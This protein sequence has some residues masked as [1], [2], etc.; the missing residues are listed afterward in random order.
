[1]NPNQ[2]FSS[3]NNGSSSIS[4]SSSVSRYASFSSSSISGSSSVSRYASFSSSSI[5]GSSS[6]SRY[7]SIVLV[8]AA[9]LNINISSSS[10]SVFAIRSQHLWWQRLMPPFYFSLFLRFVVAE[11]GVV[12]AVAAVVVVIVG[13]AVGV[14]AAVE[15]LVAVDREM[16]Q[17]W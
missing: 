2:R 11:P 6:V 3:T 15:I 16:R 17:Y 9:V 12:V 1:M 8:E 5:S 4:G 14:V 10:R 7:A 13:V